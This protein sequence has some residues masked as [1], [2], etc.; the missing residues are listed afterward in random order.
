[1]TKSTPLVG[2]I[3]K[4][5]AKASLPDM[6]TPPAPPPTPA[7]PAVEAETPSKPRKQPYYKALT[8]K[9]GYEDYM[10][11]KR[12]CFEREATTQ[13]LL[14]QAV[15]EWLSRQQKSSSV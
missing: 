4:G 3:S 15:V 12:Q 7:P 8:L 1:M 10:A 13:E 6:P 9:V 14:T 5:E 11:I 2:L